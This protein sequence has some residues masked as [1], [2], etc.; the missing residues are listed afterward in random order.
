MRLEGYWVSP[1]GEVY[2]VSDHFSWMRENAEKFGLDADDPRF[3]DYSKRDELIITALRRGWVRIRHSAKGQDQINV[4]K[5]TP[6]T[7]DKI[8]GLYT[9][10]G[11]S[12]WDAMTTFTEL[13]SG[14]RWTGTIKSLLKAM[15]ESNPKTIQ[16]LLEKHGLDAKD[17]LVE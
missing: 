9:D 7:L 12:F 15:S 1:R 17:F 8:L 5:M 4:W 11:A 10:L 6:K 14:S 13:A 16:L 2:A 3:K